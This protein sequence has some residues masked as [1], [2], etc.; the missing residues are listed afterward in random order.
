MDEKTLARLAAVMFVAL[1]IVATVIDMTRKESVAPVDASVSPAV[2]AVP[3]PLRDELARCRLLGEAGARDEA[4]LR[5]WVENRRRFLAP[6]ARP[7][8]RLPEPVAPPKPEA[9]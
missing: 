2:A 7:E 9:R 8:A 6:D 1:A 4:C 3:D 5:A